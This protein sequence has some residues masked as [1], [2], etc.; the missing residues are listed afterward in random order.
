MDKAAY[1]EKHYG[2]FKKNSTAPSKYDR[3]KDAR[4][5]GGL[6]WEDADS[7][8][9]KA[10]AVAVTEDGAALLLAKTSDGGA[11]V[12]RVVKDRE[13]TPMYPA[14]TQDLHSTLDLIKQV[15]ESA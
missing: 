1:E 2:K 15:A 4:S 13:S 3:I 10:A 11:L 7:E 5:K 9:L 8:Q 12:I 6:T 14:S